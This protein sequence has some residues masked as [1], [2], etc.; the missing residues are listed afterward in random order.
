MV[1]CNGMTLK[2]DRCRN[3]VK[4][5]NYCRFHKPNPIDNKETIRILNNQIASL[6]N[7]LRYSD[8]NKD[9]LLAEID[10]LQQKRNRLQ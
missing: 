5:G 4:I 6:R 8:L 10:K 7:Q 3:R 2:G 1:Q 9:S